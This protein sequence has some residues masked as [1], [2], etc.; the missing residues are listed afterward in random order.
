MDYRLHIAL[1][2]GLFFSGCA[3]QH[4]VNTQSEV[5]TEHEVKPVLIR[6]EHRIEPIHITVD[7]NLKI[8]RE[9]ND[10]F[11][12]LDAQSPLIVEMP[13]STGDEPATTPAP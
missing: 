4:E 5:R 11:S 8:D 12:D 9:L 2:G 13:E 7:V 3:T 6:T 1:L 10:F